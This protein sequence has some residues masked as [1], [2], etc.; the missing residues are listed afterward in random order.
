MNYIEA[1][2]FLLGLPDMERSQ[3]GARARTMSLDAMKSLLSRLGNPERGRCTAHITGSKG[4]GSTSVFL[5]SM[6]GV[7]SRTALYTSPHL[8]SYRE[9]ICF[10]LNAVSPEE[11]AAGV[12]AIR[13]AVLSEHEGQLGPISTFGAMTS[14]FFHLAT[15][16]ACD[17]Q[18]VEVGMGGLF[19]ASNVFDQKELVLIT[20]ISLEHTHMLGRSTLEIAE[21]KAGI[22]RPGCT[23]ILAPQKD[24]AVSALF[25]RK[26]LEL[27]ARL[28]DVAA[29]YEIL[30]EVYDSQGQSFSLSS[31]QGKRRF[32]LRMLG[33]HQLD[34]AATAIAAVDALNGQSLHL[35]PAEMA[36]SLANVLVPGRLELLKGSPGVVIDG[37]HNGESAA[38]L[39]SGLKRHFQISKAVFVLGVNSDKNIAEILEAIRPACSKLVI[40]HSRSEKAMDNAV[41]AEAARSLALDYQLTGSS[42]E[43]VEAAM[44]LA[45]S[46][47]FVCATG[48]LYLVAEVREY[49]RGSQPDW[50]LLATPASHGLQESTCRSSCS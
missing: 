19:D 11:F 8:H 42:Q 25:R 3:R 1:T 13:E 43:A 39:L 37:A 12:S 33:E 41:I 49:F 7:S 29:Q 14:L 28:V 40:T 24:P 34:N 47:G 27:S 45:G 21:N 16:R 18:V 26:C 4:K 35:S 48:S 17:W 9:R 36:E 30:P 5:S 32:K 23:V 10:N 15:V 38:A 20:A 46:D 31:S 2:D 6:L 50:Q 22:I 44:Q